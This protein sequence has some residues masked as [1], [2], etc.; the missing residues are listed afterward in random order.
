MTER[1]C[2][3]CSA[4]QHLT[5]EQ[6]ECRAKPPVGYPQMQIN[7]VTARPEMRMLSGYPPAKPEGW[8]RDD[9]KPSHEH[10]H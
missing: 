9:W 8:C 5:D 2:R 6:G 4:Y 10:T 3:T 1:C 7:P